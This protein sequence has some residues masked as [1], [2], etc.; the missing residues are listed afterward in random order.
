MSDC[1]PLHPEAPLLRTGLPAAGGR[2][3]PDPEHFVVDELPLY[4]PSGSG[5]HWYAL[6]R[7]RRLTTPELVRR[8]AKL[9][10]IRERDIGY[11]GLKDKHAVTS[12]WLS[13]PAQALAPESWQLPE[14]IELLGVSKHN[15]KLRS[16][17][18]R[19]NR[20]SITLTDLPPGGE[21]RA[22][23][24]LAE[25][26]RLGLPNY[27]GEQRFGHGG[28]NLAEALT[29]VRRPARRDR[30]KARFYE[31]LYPSVLQAEVFNRYLTR[32]LRLGL[33]RLIEGE[34][35][36]LSG[37]ASV[38]VVEDV[39]REQHRLKSAD[40]VLTGPIFGPRAVAACGSAAALEHEALK[41]L[42][43][44]DESLMRLGKLARGTRRDLM[45]EVG[46]VELDALSPSSLRVSFTLPSGSYATQL[47]RELTGA[48]WLGAR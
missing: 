3:G 14:E 39:E 24:I 40:V 23:D 21:S 13:L 27:F 28:Q 7:K 17:H 25:L 30:K 29:W 42:N 41:A 19:A 12:Q 10:G 38:F 46:P 6:L 48:A 1:E 37:S 32:R 36:R 47:L 15:N 31:K 45:V 11:A 2:L 35:V 22:R 9:A 26:T 44:S 33:D 18:L 43:L 4:E 5:E 8:V 20:F 16:G 34:V